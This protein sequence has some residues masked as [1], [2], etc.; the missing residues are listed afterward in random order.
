MFAKAYREYKEYVV[1]ALLFEDVEVDSFAEWAWRQFGL[2]RILANHW[3]QANA[4]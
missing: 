4:N 2:P 1:T 3:E